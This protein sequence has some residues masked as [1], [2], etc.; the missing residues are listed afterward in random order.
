[1]LI[2]F[3]IGQSEL[4]YFL[5][6][7]GWICFRPELVKIEGWYDGNTNNDDGEDASKKIKQITIH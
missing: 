4:A 2:P 7:L 6:G 1:M 3:A 5:L